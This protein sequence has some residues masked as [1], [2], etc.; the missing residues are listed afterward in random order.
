VSALVV[1]ATMIILVAATTPP[2]ESASGSANPFAGERFFVDPD[3][4]AARE[5]MAAPVDADMWRRIADHPQADWL[6]DWTPV[7]RVREEVAS[8]LGQITEQGA[9][10]VFVIY[11]IP[12][13]DCG[14]YSAGGLSGADAYRSW[15]D[16]FARG[17]GGAKAVVILEPDALA[18]VDCLSASDRDRRYTLL[19]EAVERLGARG[20]TVVYLD[21]GHSSW[22]PAETM[23]GR[24]AKAGISGARGFS[25]NVS[26]FGWT[27]EQ[28]AYGRAVSGL[29]GGKTFVVD[30][31][32]NGLGPSTVTDDPEPW[33]NPPGRAL[34]PPATTETGDPLVD[35]FV[36]VKRPGESDGTCKGG[37][38]AG[39]WW[40]EYALGLAERSSVAS[41]APGSASSASSCDEEA[42]ATHRFDDVRGSVHER[43][44]A[45][46]SRWGILLGVTESR[47]EPARTL[48]RGQIASMLVR[49]LD[50]VG[51]ELEPGES[52]DHARPTDIG[53]TAHEGAILRLVETEVIRGYDDG[54]YRPGQPVTRAQFASLLI[55]AFAY[56]TGET[57][58]S[59]G[60]SFSDTAGSP[61]AGAIGAAAERGWIHGFPDGTFRPGLSVNRAHAAAMTDRMLAD[62]VDSGHG[63]GRPEE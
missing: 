12:Q 5:A 19:R 43:A 26:N 34:G 61:H 32:R 54:T 41:P 14:S 6:G 56:V 2:A 13:R 57:V 8:R 24:L 40:P 4:D 44:V 16:E 59:K 33:C 29:V 37:P 20:D 62:L 7:D 15:I 50:A 18:Q 28:I 58:A 51:V 63:D 1:A 30:T 10:P 17:L 36:W 46:L 31:S 25:L 38:A 45:C 9:L 3:S 53:G 42:V 35:A 27:S 52:A 39:T 21:A 23:A 47:F 49:F 55:R 11:A 48:N 22:I 60:S